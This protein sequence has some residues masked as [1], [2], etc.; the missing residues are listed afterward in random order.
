MVRGSKIAIFIRN[1]LTAI[2]GMITGLIDIPTSIISMPPSM[3]PTFGVALKNI[4]NIFNPE[5]I[6]SNIYFLIYGFL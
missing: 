4:G 1:G 5:M 2:V 3:A 6:L